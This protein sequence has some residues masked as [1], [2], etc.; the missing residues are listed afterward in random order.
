MRWNAGDAR[1]KIVNMTKHAIAGRFEASRVAGDGA[2]ANQLVA[3]ASR[4]A[5]TL[6][7]TLD[8]PYLAELKQNA[9]IRRLLETGGVPRLPADDSEV[10]SIYM[11]HAPRVFDQVIADETLTFVVSDWSKAFFAHLYRM[12][13]PGGRLI[14]PV[15]RGP[16]GRAYGRWRLEDF[17]AFFGGEIDTFAGLDLAIIPVKAGTAAA[18]ASTASWFIDHSQ[19]LL[20]QHG[21]LAASNEDARPDFNSILSEADSAKLSG[22]GIGMFERRLE[23]Y[24]TQHCYYA[25]GISYKAP[26]LS[27]I[28]RSHAEKQS[29]LRA[30]DMGGGYGLLTAELLLDHS[31]G[32]EEGTCTDISD[33]NARLAAR[34]YADLGDELAGRFRFVCAPAQG[35]DFDGQYDVISYVGSLLYV[36]KNQ[37]DDVMRRTWE[38]VAPGGI[39]IVHENIKHPRF[40]RDFPIM[41]TVEEI[42]A[43]MEPLG[44]VHRYA[45]Q[46]TQP[47]TKTQATEKTVF[48]VVKKAG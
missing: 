46:Y 26:L 38:A 45:S 36:P 37:L 16:D 28:I 18:F 43:L 27:H 42:D 6:E 33:L 13:R 15:Y 35:F 14:L 2:L 32:V 11:C 1:E 23:Q 7:R 48:R 4:T 41:F 44:E 10:G 34:M 20:L 25:G 22:C 8:R 24:T 5:A 21:F 9:D 39:L 19:S 3:V 12:V 17:S 30:I 40:T 31:I 29:G 47:L